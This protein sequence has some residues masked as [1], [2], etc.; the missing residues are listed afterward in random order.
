MERRIIRHEAT[1]GIV[2]VVGGHA[3]LSDEKGFPHR[4]C[5]IFGR[6]RHGERREAK[7]GEGERGPRRKDPKVDY[8][9]S[10]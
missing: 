7:R 10:I 4:W 3:P 8:G 5:R 2:A 6:G 9:I 1:D